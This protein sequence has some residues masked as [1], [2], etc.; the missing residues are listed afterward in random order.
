LI[1]FPL[2]RAKCKHSE[3]RDSGKKDKKKKRKKKKKNKEKKKE[4]RFFFLFKFDRL[5]KEPTSFLKTKDHN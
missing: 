5:S 4:K 2:S 3:I 1:L